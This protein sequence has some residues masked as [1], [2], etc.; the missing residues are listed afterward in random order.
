M[1]YQI[2]LSVAAFVIFLAASSAIF[3]QSSSRVKF[4]KGATSAN[5]V[6]K[7]N[8][9]KDNKIYRIKVREG[10]TLNTEQ[11]M[12]EASLHYISVSITDPSGADVTDSDA[13]CNSRKE[14]TPTAAGDYVI[15]V[16][17]CQ[18]ADKWRGSF[19]L[20]VTVK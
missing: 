19:K 5:I 7:L 12:N 10:Q 9:F 6:G 1:K 15:T 4:A 16:Y 17:E 18:K 14:V 11:I 20:K 3:A 13:S 8:G 2:K